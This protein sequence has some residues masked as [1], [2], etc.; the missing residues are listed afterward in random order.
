MKCEENVMADGPYAFF[1]VDDT[2]IS[3][4]SMLSFQAF[5]YDQTGDELGRVSYEQDLRKHLHSGASWEFLNRLYYR[6]FAGREP[7]RV[8]ALGQAWFEQQRKSELPFYHA[9]PLAELEMHQRQG[10]EVVFVSGSFPALLEPIA[11]ELGVFHI[12]STRMAVEG[13]RYT[14]EILSPQ[15]IGSGKA[16]AIGEFLSQRQCSP[17]SCFAYGDDISDLPMLRAVGQ[18]TVV[19]GG[20]EL[21]ARARAMGWRVIAPA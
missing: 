13:G 10:C 17:E 21:E 3:V 2:L 6:H 9:R 5:W 16:E 12:L 19:S 18:P 7:E 4:K 20:R 8:A 14:G 15:T 11:R 1:D